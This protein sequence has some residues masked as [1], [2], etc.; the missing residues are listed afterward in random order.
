[1][2][3]AQ[4]KSFEIAALSSLKVATATLVSAMLF[5]RVAMYSTLPLPRLAHRFVVV[6]QSGI[7]IAM[8]V[9]ALPIAVEAFVL[10]FDLGA[11]R[12]IASAMRHAAGMPPHR[13]DACAC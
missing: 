6:L 3:A 13:R 12:A 4:V 5:D 10:P 9:N 7:H 2:R 11:A 8:Q 1:M